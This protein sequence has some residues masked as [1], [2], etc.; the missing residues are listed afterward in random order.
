M[1]LLEPMVA[2]IEKENVFSMLSMP[3]L[4]PINPS[5]LSTMVDVND[6]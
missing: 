2:L 6:R 4:A 3:A 1:F 5:G